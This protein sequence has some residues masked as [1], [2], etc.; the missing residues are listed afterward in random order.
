ME[1]AA[2]QAFG[3]LNSDVASRLLVNLF[4]PGLINLSVKFAIVFC[5]VT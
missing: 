2:C 5:Y 1:N 3:K 4:T